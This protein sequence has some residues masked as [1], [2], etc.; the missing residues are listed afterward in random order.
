MLDK[1]QRLHT[2]LETLK[3]EMSQPDISSNISKLTELSKEYKRLLPISE[4]FLKYKK[5][6]NDLKTTQQFLRIETDAEL[7]Q[8]AKEEL[9]KLKINQ[10]ELEENY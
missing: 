3:V 1:L 9:E 8:M 4:A 2:R 7:K 10:A 5:L 6:A